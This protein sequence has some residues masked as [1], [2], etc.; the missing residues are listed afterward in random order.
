MQLASLDRSNF[1]QTAIVFLVTVAAVCLFGIIAAY[2]T[3]VWLAP[4]PEAS[5]PAAVD[6]GSGT[7]AAALFGKSQ[8]DRVSAASPGTST[9]RLLGVVAAAEGHLGYAVLNLDS[10]ETLAVL[11]GED[12]APGIR[13]VEVGVDHVVLERGAVRETLTW[14]QTNAAPE[15]SALR[16]RR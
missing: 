10:G 6:T 2:W 16:N 1:P 13:L 9:I 8:G 7:S 12:V 3:W 15:A 4:R 14:P 11:E 5:T